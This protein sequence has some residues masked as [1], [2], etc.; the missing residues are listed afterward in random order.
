MS[1]PET[2]VNFI[3]DVFNTTAERDIYTGDS[4][5]VVIKRLGQP[6]ETRTFP[7]RKDWKLIFNIY[8][9]YKIQI[10]FNNKYFINYIINNNL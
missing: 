3:V 1:D 8:I 4:I 5:Y 2:L 7:L 9:I 10:F 6:V